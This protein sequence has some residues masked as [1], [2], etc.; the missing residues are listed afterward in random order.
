MK[1]DNLV[2]QENGAVSS[3]V[4]E[5]NIERIKLMSMPLTRLHFQTKT[6][7]FTNV[8]MYNYNIKMLRDKI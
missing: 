6:I 1:S 4:V 2:H 7:Q 8:S 3:D 5:D